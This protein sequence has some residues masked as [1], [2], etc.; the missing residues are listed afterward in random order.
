MCVSKQQPARA[1]PAAGL[2]TDREAEIREV[3][4]A[5]GFVGAAAERQLIA[6][7]A[8]VIAPPPSGE[9]PKP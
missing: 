7:L 2:T 1:Q 4:V 6:E 5:G 9:A 8:A 3:V